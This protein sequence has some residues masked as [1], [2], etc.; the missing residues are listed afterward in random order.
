MYSL[1]TRI[2]LSFWLVALL[3]G[4]SMFIAERYLGEDAIRQETQRVE[5]HAATV[6]ALLADGG[7]EAV[8]R[9]LATL[10]RRDHAPMFLIDQDGTPLITHPMPPP[11]RERLERAQ[12]EPGVHVIRPGMVSIVSAI[13]NSD[14]PL[15]LGTVL[16]LK[17]VETVPFWMRIAAAVI[18]SG[19]VCFALAA[20]ITRPIR[21]L[22]QAAQALAGGDLT[23]RVPVRG[24]D[25]V[26]ALA[27][28]FNVM[29]DRVRD[30]L[31]AQKRL[32]RDVSHELRSPLA[33]LRVALELARKKGDTTTALDRIERDAERLEELVSDVLTLSRIE[34][35]ASKPQ[36]QSVALDDLIAAVAQDASFEAA[37]SGK[38][39]TADLAHEVA[40]VGDSAVL[41]SA[42]ENVV[43]NAVRY[44]APGSAVNISLRIENSDAVIVVR[45]HGA[46]VPEQELGKLFQPFS[47]IGDARDRTSGGYGLGLAISRQ[48]VE[49]HGGTI[50]A[51]N[52][53]G[54]GLMV[55]LRLPLAAGMCPL[56]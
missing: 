6:S 18:F 9:W 30:L 25:E 12:F 2:F 29:A 22:R 19:V 27:R 45:D 32:L 34:A 35:A 17:R 47:R 26:A 40:V 1:F 55:T 7:M 8:Q 21:R 23:V 24:R 53:E 10:M 13:P 36:R 14:P 5:A 42:V 38:S 41:R 16:H 49:S 3:L 46:G 43:R 51:A 33:R 28:D 44:T 4:A 56:D 15:Y 48:A 11:L 50:T 54:G 37:A 31:E 39:V 20:L 52:A